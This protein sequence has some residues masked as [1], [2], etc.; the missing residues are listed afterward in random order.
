MAAH[1]AAVLAAGDPAFGRAFAGVEVACVYRLEDPAT[2][3][4]VRDADVVEGARAIGVTLGMPA[5]GTVGVV[6]DVLADRAFLVER[7]TSAAE[8]G[9]LADLGSEDPDVVVAALA[10]A[11]LA[12]AFGVES[13]AVRDGLRS[14]RA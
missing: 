6:E 8:L 9:T 2:E 3:D 5:V 4:L 13:A 1:S 10:A 11:A 12:R 7:R 14:H